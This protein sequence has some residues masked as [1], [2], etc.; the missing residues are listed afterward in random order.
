[1]LLDDSFEQIS[2]SSRWD[3][4]ESAPTSQIGLEVDTTVHE[5][6]PRISHQHQK[7]LEHPPILPRFPSPFGKGSMA[8]PP[9]AV[10]TCQTFPAGKQFLGHSVQGPSSLRTS[11]QVGGKPKPKPRMNVP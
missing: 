9:H 10:R 5:P 7:T 3:L 4:V 6:T 1:M 2:D 8:S 11:W